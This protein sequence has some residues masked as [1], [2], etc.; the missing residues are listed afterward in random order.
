MSRRRVVLAFFAVTACVDPAEPVDGAPIVADQQLTTFEDGAVWFKVEASDPEGAPVSLTIGAPAHGILRASGIGWT[1]EPDREFSGN[2]LVIVR[3]SDGA[4]E[5]LA[6]VAI[7]VITVNDKPSAWFD[8]VSTP[9]DTVLYVSSEVLVAND[10]DLEAAALEVVA[11]SDAIG[12]TVALVDGEVVFMPAQHFAGTARFRYTMSDGEIHDSAGVDVVVGPVNDP[13]IAYTIVTSTDEDAGV[14]IKP[15]GIDVDSVRLTWAV[16]DHPAH[17]TLTLSDS[18]GYLP[19][20][21]FHG[22]DSFT[23]AVSDGQMSSAPA[24]VAIHVKRVLECG[25]REVEGAETCDDGNA[26][27]G[28]GCSAECTSEGFAL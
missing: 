26:T 11:V 4:Q 17:G 7:R 24:T 13:P 14:A 19:D 6:E 5:S 28:D 12:G 10:L 9:E 1:Y 2:D 18:I 8:R 22:E 16:I 27:D 21:D 3:V 25:D 23:Y 15:H 20:V